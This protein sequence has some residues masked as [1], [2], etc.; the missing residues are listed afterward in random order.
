MTIKVGQRFTYTP[1]A[2]WTEFRDGNR[3]VH[4]GPNGEEL[5]VSGS[6][7]SPKEDA[8]GH[9]DENAQQALL[10]VGLEAALAGVADPELNVCVPLAR[11]DGICPFPV[12]ITIAETE[13]H[14]TVFCVAV[15]SQADA[16][17]FV[18]FEAPHGPDIVAT[19]RRILSTVGNAG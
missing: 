4:Q 9:V 3:R 6:F 7:V 18:T 5:I 19:F 8:A 12:W 13:N 15:V 16:V 1:P 2:G 11:E 10:S 14:D 17:L